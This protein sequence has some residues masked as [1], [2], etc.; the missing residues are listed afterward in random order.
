MAKTSDKAAQD[1]YRKLAKK[2]LDALSELGR[3]SEG[4]V[5]FFV[6]KRRGEVDLEEDDSSMPGAWVEVW[7]YIHL[8]FPKGRKR[9]NHLTLVEE[10]KA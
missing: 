3:A 5:P 8:P 7:A 2:Q 10:E 9:R 4:R 6:V 1:R